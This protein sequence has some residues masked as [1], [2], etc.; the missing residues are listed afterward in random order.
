MERADKAQRK[1]NKL[2]IKRRS[3]R[4][5]VGETIVIQAQRVKHSDFHDSS[6]EFRY[7]SDLRRFR[8]RLLRT[9][10]TDNK[11][12]FLVAEV[13]GD[14]TN[15]SGKALLLAPASKEASVERAIAVCIKSNATTACCGGAH[16][17][18]LLTTTGDT[19]NLV[20][21]S[22]AGN[23]ICGTPLLLGNVTI[24]VISGSVFSHCKPRD[25]AFD[26]TVVLQLQQRVAVL[27]GFKVL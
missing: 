19:A 6:T 13:G 2:L 3:K 14:D 18:P 9:T 11:R 21:D 12:M 8:R 1:L 5:N 10:G 23:V 16:S 7:S 27:L 26:K 4:G 24:I 15:R 20:F 22:K 25:L 17:L